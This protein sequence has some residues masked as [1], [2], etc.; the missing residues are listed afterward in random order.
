MAGFDL[1]QSKNILYKKYLKLRN[2]LS[3]DFCATLNR[4]SVKSKPFILYDNDNNLNQQCENNLNIIDKWKWVQY[5]PAESVCNEN[6][7]SWINLLLYKDKIGLSSLIN[8]KWIVD[9]PYHSLSLKSLIENKNNCKKKSSISSTTITCSR[10]VSIRIG[11]KSLIKPVVIASHNRFIERILFESNIT[12]NNNKYDLLHLTND[13]SS[14]LEKNSPVL[15]AYSSS[16]NNQPNIIWYHTSKELI[17]DDNDNDDNKDDDNDNNSNDNNNDYND[18]GDNNNNNNKYNKFSDFL[19]ITRRV[20]DNRELTISVDSKFINS[21]HDNAVVIHISEI[22]PDFIDLIFSSYKYKFITT[23][24]TTTTTTNNVNNNKV[25]M[26][27]K[28]ISSGFIA[29]LPSFAYTGN[30]CRSKLEMEIEIN[31]NNNNNNNN[32]NSNLI[33]NSLNPFLSNNDNYNDERINC[34]ATST[35]S[36]ILPPNTTLITHF[37]GKKRFLKADVFPS[38]PSRG[39]EYPPSIIMEKWYNYNNEMKYNNIYNDLNYASSQYILNNYH[40]FGPYLEIYQTITKAT[41]ILLPIPDASMSFN[42][43]TLV[44]TVFAFFLGSMINVMRRKRNKKK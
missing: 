30:L 10:N 3:A 17:K 43:I 4:D 19:G 13:F 11:I 1:N 7:A 21:N 23:T 34:F 38:D 16:Y 33:F 42:V 9:S 6:I 27:V 40:Q 24:T 29:D 37:K 25:N 26:E 31:N 44:S 15:S 8:Y 2:M 5:F 39:M 18:N 41:L 35:F 28:D 22:I 14:D 36:F 32:V 20:I 12:N